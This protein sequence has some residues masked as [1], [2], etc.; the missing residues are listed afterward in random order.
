MAIEFT[1]GSPCYYISDS[2][3]C[4]ATVVHKIYN[5]D[6]NSHEPI[7]RRRSRSGAISVTRFDDQ[8]HGS[9]QTSL[10]GSISN[11][12]MNSESTS[13]VVTHVHSGE[14][15]TD[16]GVGGY[17]YC[18]VGETPDEYVCG[19]CAKVLVVVHVDRVILHMTSAP[20]LSMITF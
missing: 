5:M 10:K 6:V 2:A 3:V 18:F 4:A 19:I 11:D 16:A 7:A 8:A 17:D 13:K 9:V 20:L 1:S 12:S 14:K 15:A